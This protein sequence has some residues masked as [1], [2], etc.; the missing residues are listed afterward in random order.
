MKTSWR[1][2]SSSASEDVLIKANIFALLIRLQRTLLRR[3]QDVSIN[4][5]I[6]VL[7]IRLQ[8]VFK[9]FSRFLQDVFKMSLRRLTKMSQNRLQ[10]VFK[11]SCKN[12]FK[13]SSRSLQDVLKTYHQVKLFLL[14][15][16]Q[17]VFE[18]YSKRFSDVIQRCLSTEGFLLVTLLRK[19]WPV[20]NICKTGKSFSNF[21]FFTT[22]FRSCL[23]R[24]IY[25]L[26][27]HCNG[28]FFAKII[29]GFKLFTIF[30]K[31]LLRRCLTGMEIGFW[32]RAWNI[33]LNLVQSLQIKPKNYSARNY[34]WHC[35][36]K[37]ESHGG[38]VNRTSV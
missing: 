2:H 33:E 10:D 21:S 30:A 22:P 9:T 14:T 24:R 37:G 18:T 17:D 20:Y 26:V 4:T 34:A 7:V 31:E 25:N 8:D 13:T 6:F 32:Q 27:E 5:K 28:A 1:R 23:Q 11:T 29:N 19:V 16:S 36:L 35:F 12:V 38:T 3:F 15:W